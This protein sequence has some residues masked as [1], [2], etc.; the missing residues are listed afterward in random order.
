MYGHLR[1][2]K[3]SE[4]TCKSV[5]QIAG[6]YKSSKL[7]KKELVTKNSREYYILILKR[8]KDNSLKQITSKG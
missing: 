4:S 6:I 5:K 3:Y 8:Y 2:S 1:V 7:V